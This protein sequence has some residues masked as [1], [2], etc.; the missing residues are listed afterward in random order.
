L[1]H[2]RGEHALE[3]AFETPAK[4]NVPEFIKE[5][6]PLSIAP[7]E[8]TVED[9]IK[10]AEDNGFKQADIVTGAKIYHNQ[11]NIYHLTSEQI[12]DLDR[13]MTARIEKTKV[14]SQAE[15][16]PIKRAKVA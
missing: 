7:K 1:D 9:L 16:K 4:S 6:T 14:Q 11:S 12:A 2:M 15:E 10:K 3:L 5:K 13:R 8:M